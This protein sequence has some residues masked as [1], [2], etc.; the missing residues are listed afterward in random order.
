MCGGTT[1]GGGSVMVWGGITANDRTPLVVIDRNLT[2][3]RHRDEILQTHVIPFI[4]GQQCNDTFQHDNARPHV[5]RVAMD[6]LAQHNVNVLPWP[7]V[8]PDLSPI[9]H[10]WDEMERRL[11]HLPNQPVTLQGLAQE[12]DQIW[13]SIPQAF[14]RHIITSMRRCCQS[15]VNANGG[16]TRY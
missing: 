15:C 8:S 7:A 3:V 10:V 4:Q 1:F 6:F 11:H 13:N 12:L 2:G 9:E 16:H 14:F 5:A